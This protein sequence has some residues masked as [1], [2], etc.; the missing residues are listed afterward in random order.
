LKSREVKKPDLP[1]VCMKCGREAAVWKSKLFDWESGRVAALRLLGPVPVGPKV[2]KAQLPLCPRHRHHWLGRTAFAW[3][4][5]GFL[6][7]GFG[8]MIA[9][10]ESGPRGGQP[11]KAFMILAAISCAG[12]PIWLIIML[13]L[14][15]TAI[16]PVEISED[17]ITLKGVSPKFVESLEARRRRRAEQRR[18]RREP[19]SPRDDGP[20]PFDNAQE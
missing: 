2:M 16:R 15:A 18:Q 13:F 20:L 3:G 14:L 1:F 5:G 10:V 7:A 4:V 8:I 19:G 9:L 17:S 11:P 6:L 12:L